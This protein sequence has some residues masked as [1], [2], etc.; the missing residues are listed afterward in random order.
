MS[1]VAMNCACEGKE[2]SLNGKEL[3]HDSVMLLEYRED[4]IHHQRFTYTK[5]GLSRLHDS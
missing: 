3:S 5:K 1:Y 4:I 2:L